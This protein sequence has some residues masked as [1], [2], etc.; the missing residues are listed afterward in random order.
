VFDKVARMLGL[1]GGGAELAQLADTATHLYA[2]PMPIARTQQPLDFSFSG[3]KTHMARLINA[4]PDNQLADQTPAIAASFQQAVIAAL[5]KKTQLA[6][7]QT[8]R[9]QLALVGGVSQNAQFRALLAAHQKQHPQLRVQMPLVPY[10][11][12]NAA[13]IAS[14]AYYSPL[15]MGLGPDAFSRGLMP[16]WTP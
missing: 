3:L 11:T 13:M 1:T 8:G 10:C 15:A 4:I 2:S 7:A 14:A 6:L 12:D 16:G 5:W 9:Q